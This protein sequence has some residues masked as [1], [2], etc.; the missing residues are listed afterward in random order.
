MLAP[1]SEAAEGGPL[2]A[3]GARSLGLFD[4]FVATLEA[5]TGI[6]VGYERSGTLHVAR[7]EESIADF[8]V[9]HHDT[10]RN[11]VASERLS[12]IEARAHEPNLAADI[13]GGLLIPVQGL[14]LGADDDAR[15]W[16]SA[17]E[18]RGATLLEPTHAHRIGAAGR[19]RAHRDGPRAACT[20][21]R[22][23]L[24]AG[25]WSGQLEIDGIARCGAGQ[26][27]SR[28]AAAPRLGGH[29]DRAHHVG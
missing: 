13:F 25:A 21:E 4:E 26:A 19:R 8:E 5:E 2:L 18:R 7:A 17:S 1:Y 27:R 12:A 9:V 6:S 28:A 29:A 11:G 15:D 14:D 24:A 3:L 16:L 10:L 20:P 22:S 23:V